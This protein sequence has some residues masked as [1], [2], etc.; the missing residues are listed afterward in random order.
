[1]YAAMRLRGAQDAPVVPAS[2]ALSVCADC[3]AVIYAARASA[4]WTTRIILT[5]KVSCANYGGKR[6]RLTT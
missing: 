3:T 2:C 4:L 6:K 5:R 1:M